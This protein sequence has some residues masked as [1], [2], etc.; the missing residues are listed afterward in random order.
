MNQ[1]ANTIK[2]QIGVKTL[3]ACGARNFLASATSLEMEVLEDARAVIKLLT[4][5][6]NGK[7]LYDVEL[8]VLSMR[9][10]S[11]TVIEEKTDIFCEN[12]SDV[13]YRMCNK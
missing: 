13:V 7:D 1:V 9:H 12:L 8:V 2:Q 10:M 5:T 11:R 4:V 3:M 6:L